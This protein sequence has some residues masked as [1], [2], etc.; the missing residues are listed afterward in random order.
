MLRCF[1][2]SG[3][4]QDVGGSGPA[5]GRN[6]SALPE[7]PVARGARA[8]KGAYS[9]RAYPSHYPSASLRANVG[10]TRGIAVAYQ[11]RGGFTMGRVRLWAHRGNFMTRVTS[12]GVPPQPVRAPLQLRL[13]ACPRGFA[14][15]FLCLMREAPRVV[16]HRVNEPKFAA[17]A[18]RGLCIFSP[19][20]K[21]VLGQ[22]SLR[23]SLCACRPSGFALARLAPG[24][25]RRARGQDT[26][27]TMGRRAR[28]QPHL[29]R[30]NPA[31]SHSA[32]AGPSPRAYLH[33]H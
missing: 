29:L 7:E 33:R 25:P 23:L 32:S 14:S 2:P 20:R 21:E 15:F 11:S 6:A 8:A 27:A 19:F 1:V 24:D 22:E 28:G 18:R 4:S 5:Y 3:L 26:K 31:P 12:R 10:L 9:C 13:R 30:K 16:L 17:C